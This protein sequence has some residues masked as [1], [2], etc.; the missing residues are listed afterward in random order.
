MKLKLSTL[1]YIMLGFSILTSC[2]EDELSD[3]S[4]FVD[5][6]T[7]EN[8]F[9]RWITTN[10]TKPYNIAF[11]YRFEDIES[12]M[13][14]YLTPADYKQSIA[15]SK[16][17][18]HLCLQ[19][20]DEVTD[21]TTFIRSY[22][23]KIIFLSGSPAYKNNGSMILGTADGGKKITL[24]NVDALNPSA[25]TAESSYFKTIHHEF[26]HILNQ[27]KPYSTDFGKISGNLYVDES[28][29][30][31]YTTESSALKAG[32]ISRYAASGHGE[33]FVEL[34]SIYVT[35]TPE[36]WNAMLETA[37]ETGRAIIEEKFEIVF[38]YML[39]NWNINLNDLRSAVLR[40]TEEVKS[41]DL[42]SLDD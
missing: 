5:S 19:A 29:W 23:P 36:K 35:R 31:T 4:I 1:L 17:V 37:G 21:G 2:K 3:T 6:I 7:E 25:I 32:F 34:E 26:G 39:A 11:K 10:Y 30:D 14:Y 42:Y 28:C 12:S 15:M 22:F 24:F 20:Y 13:S 27:T 18:R 41:M 8:D 38:N 33:D 16:L 40:R 9:D